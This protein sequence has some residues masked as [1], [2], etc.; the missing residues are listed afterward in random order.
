[1]GSKNELHR[2]INTH[3]RYFSFFY[4][5]CTQINRG[6]GSVLFVYDLV[7]PFLCIGM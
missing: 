3:Q 6:F 7:K 1:M 2:N 4:R 5:V